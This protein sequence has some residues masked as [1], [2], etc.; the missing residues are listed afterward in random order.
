MIEI[1]RLG[2]DKKPVRLSEISRRTGISR[3]FLDQLAVELR[4]RSLI[5]A[6]R[7]RNGGYSLKRSP[8][9]ISVRDVITAVIGPISLAVCV[10]D[11]NICMSSDFCE[12]RLIWTLL[13]KQIDALL[14]SYSLADLS[15][16]RTLAS[17]RE[18][19]EAEAKARI[20]REEGLGA[21]SAGTSAIP[22]CA[23][24]SSD[25]GCLDR[26]RANRNPRAGKAKKPRNG[27]ALPRGRRQ[28]P[29]TPSPLHRRT[30]A[31]KQDD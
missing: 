1:D 8:E 23:Q 9:T 6:V 13:Q 5:K 30:E 19:I 3:R 31:Q 10:E 21:P 28:V 2:K 7:G 20:Y 18:W 16:S 12:I 4:N 25:E 24:I 14:D 27:R 15:D 17:I 22:S 11:P 26:S 29:L